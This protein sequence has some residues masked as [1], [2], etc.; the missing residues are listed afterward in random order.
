MDCIDLEIHSTVSLLIEVKLFS[1]KPKNSVEEI[2]QIHQIL[3]E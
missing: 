3:V 1:L 2:H